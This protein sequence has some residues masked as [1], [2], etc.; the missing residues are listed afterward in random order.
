[1]Q[2]NGAKHHIP[3]AFLLYPTYQT[4]PAQQYVDVLKLLHSADTQVYW[5]VA[6]GW[7]P[8]R[9][10][11][12]DIPAPLGAATFNVKV[13]LVDNDKDIRP[14]YVTAAAGGVSQTL[15]PTVPDHGEQLNILQFTLENVPAG[16]NKIVLTI[17]SPAPPDG[18]GGLAALGLD[19][20]GPGDDSG[21]RG[22][23]SGALV[24]VTAN[25]VCTPI[26]D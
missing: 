20:G 21:T 23:D 2:P 3:R 14:I 5:N 18:G 19:H 8:L 9:Q 25:Y 17:E 22:G 7:I 12:I 24:G 1:L 11:E 16:T 10:V 15:Q 13:A 6:G 26:P 4:A